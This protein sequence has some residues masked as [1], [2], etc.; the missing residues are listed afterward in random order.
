MF[1]KIGG[2]H[3]GLTA[4]TFIAGGHIIAYGPHGAAWGKVAASVPQKSP[5]MVRPGRDEG[6]SRLVGKLKITKFRLFL[7]KLCQLARSSLCF[8]GGSSTFV[9]TIPWEKEPTG[10]TS[11]LESTSLPWYTP[12]FAQ[13]NSA[14]REYIYGRYIMASTAEALKVLPKWPYSMLDIKC[15]S[16]VNETPWDRTHSGQAQQNNTT[17]QQSKPNQLTWWGSLSNMYGCQQA[18]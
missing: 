16:L 5:R 10:C 4:T 9:A 1:P 17:Q 11:Y 13:K 18:Q 6:K 8:L 3:L 12:Q 2:W 15:G 14:G 7:M